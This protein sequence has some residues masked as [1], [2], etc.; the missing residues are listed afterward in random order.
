MDSISRSS[1]PL[2]PLCLR[3]G[4][5]YPICVPPRLMLSHSSTSGGWN[6]LHPNIRLDHAPTSPASQLQRSFPWE[7]FD[8]PVISCFVVPQ[9]VADPI[10]QWGQQQLQVAQW[11]CNLLRQSA[12]KTSWEGIRRQLQRG[13]L[14]SC[15]DGSFSNDVG[16]F[17]FVIA[18]KQRQ[19]LVYGS[20]PAPGAY[21][22]SFRSEA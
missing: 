3:Q 14:I 15:S 20:G 5:R 12:L 17:G 11:E 8:L 19:C 22:N 7:L 6:V 16:A 13:Q 18:T 10:L 9:P 4:L 1:S 2:V 21:S